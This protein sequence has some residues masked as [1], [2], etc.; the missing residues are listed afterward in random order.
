MRHELF[1]L[2][3]ALAGVGLIGCSAEA[4]SASEA[5]EDHGHDAQ[6]H[7]PRGTRVGLDGGRAT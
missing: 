5:S 6:G 3:L 2:A 7:L 1:G 4:P